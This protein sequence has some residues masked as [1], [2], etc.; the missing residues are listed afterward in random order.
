MNPIAKLTHAAGFTL[1]ILASPSLRADEKLKDIACRSV[2]LS[3]PAPEAL[4]FYNEVKVE[5]S[6]IGTYFMVCG[7]RDGYF[8]MQEGY[9]GAKQ[10]IFSVWDAFHTDDPKA[11]PAGQRVLLLHQDPKV[12]VGRFGG[13]GTGGQSFFKY[14]W[15][16]GATYRFMVTAQ[17]AGVRTAFTGWFFVPEAKA[18]KRLVTFSTLTEG[19]GLQKLYSFVEDF[20]RDRVSTGKVRRASYGNGWALGQD[21][22]WSFLR[23]A[24]FTGDR[25]PV[26]NINAGRSGDAFFLATGGETVNLDTP[27]GASTTLPAAVQGTQPQDLPKF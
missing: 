9:D 2:H 23:E 24:K 18:W 14:P 27:L 5:Q 8:G 11:V 10:V 15:K 7:W 22:A 17:P 16:R 21:G 25:N 3:Y 6:A 26:L 12:R 1:A 19:R 13:E 4:A 20:K